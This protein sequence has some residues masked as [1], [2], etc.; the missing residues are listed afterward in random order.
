MNIM[1]WLV[2]RLVTNK[3]KGD[4]I[5][6]WGRVAEAKKVEKRCVLASV[7]SVG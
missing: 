6:I 2:A 7:S 4:G 1:V 3:G 5:L